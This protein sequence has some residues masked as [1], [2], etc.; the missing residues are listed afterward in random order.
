MKYFLFNLFQIFNIS[1]NQC[2]YYV[3]QV[4][5]ENYPTTTNHN[6]IAITKLIYLLRAIKHP[7]ALWFCSPLS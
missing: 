7:L 2:V 4:I 3:L 6:S 1:V 5:L